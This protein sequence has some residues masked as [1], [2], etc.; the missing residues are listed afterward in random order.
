MVKITARCTAAVPSRFQS[1]LYSRFWSVNFY[2][3]PTAPGEMFILI[4]HAKTQKER[5]EWDMHYPKEKY[6]DIFREIAAQAPIVQPE[7]RCFDIKAEYM[8]PPESATAFLVTLY[9]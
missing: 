8:A 5:H 3:S 9:L 6:I 4:Y 1:Q 7:F 2:S